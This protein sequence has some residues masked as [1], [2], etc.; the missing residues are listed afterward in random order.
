MAEPSG[1]L[2]GHFVRSRSISSRITSGPGDEVGCEALLNIPVFRGLFG[3]KFWINF[4]KKS[5]FVRGRYAKGGG[6][7]GGF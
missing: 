5:I 6:G 1:A 2:Q 3:P 4:L 7:G